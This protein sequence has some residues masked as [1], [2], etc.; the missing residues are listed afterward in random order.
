MGK[1]NTKHKKDSLKN[2]LGFMPFL[3]VCMAFEFVPIIFLVRG[4]FIDKATQ[5]LTLAHYQAMSRTIYVNSFVNSIKIS[6]LTA[7]IGVV[8]GTLIGYAIYK[9][10]SEGVK[11][12]LISL[13]DVTTNFSGAPLAFA[14]I[15]ILGMNGVI[16]QFVLKYFSYEM[17]PKFSI[18]S[19]SGL[20]LA[21]VYFQLPLMVLTII[22]AFVGI[23][24]EWQESAESLGAN[25]FQFWRHIGIPILGPSLLAGLTLLFANAY[26]AYATAYTLVESQLSLVTL[27]IG[28]MIA[29]EVR[30]D[31][32]IGMAMA[33]LSLI[34]MGLSIAIYQITI[35]KV[36]RWS[37]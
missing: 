9:L 12:A 31:P 2:W 8:L 21:Y 35:S 16:T 29:G 32:G 25:T 20:V 15:I 34:I 19:F 11:N 7:I 28:F 30:H 14:F 24:K 1:T 6:G 3:L 13:S 37:K 17:Y 27:Q 26:G 4:S 5:Q 23:K 10:P 18:Y 33:V 22:P 36:R